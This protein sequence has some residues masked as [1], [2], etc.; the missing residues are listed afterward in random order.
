MTGEKEVAHPI[1]PVWDESSEILIL[2]SFPS[3]KSRETGF[4]YGHPQNRFWR[5]LSSVLKA[6]EPVGTDEKKAMLLKYHIALWDVAA[7]CVVTVSSDSSIKDARPNDIKPIL[8]GSRVKK[9]CVN[10][11]TA[12]RLY[13]KYILPYSG[14]KP[15]LLPSTSPA[16]ASWSL[17][18]LIAVWSKIININETKQEVKE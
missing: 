8:E 14:L 9:I 10:G 15:E 3:V 18:R 13:L 5:V 2:G 12:E 6:P 4:Y 1:P 7:S 11:K 17:E 16:N